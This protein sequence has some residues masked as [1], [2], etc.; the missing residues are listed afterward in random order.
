VISLRVLSNNHRNFEMAQM[1][2]K[3]IAPSRSA[4]R[5]WRKITG[6]PCARETKAH[7]K[8]G[9][10]LRVVKNFARHSH[11]LTQTIS[12]GII[13]R[14]AGFM[15]FSSWCLACDQNSSLRVHLQNG[16][17]PVRQMYLT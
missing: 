6:F 9:N 11:P 17:S 13:E 2:E 4:L 5:S 15:N 14:H 10:M 16:T 8:N 12:A 1:T 3:L 7:W